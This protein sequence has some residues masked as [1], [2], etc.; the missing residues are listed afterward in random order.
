MTIQKINWIK[1]LPKNRMIKA[2][3][4]E[5]DESFDCV[6]NRNK[7]C[8]SR[9]PLEVADVRN[10]FLAKIPKFMELFDVQNKA[11][12]K[13]YLCVKLRYVILNEVRKLRNNK[14]KI[15]N[16]RPILS[17]EAIENLY[18]DNDS[19]RGN[20]DFS[21]LNKFEYLVFLEIFESCSSIATAARELNVTRYL[22]YK[23][24]ETIKIK[25]KK[26]LQ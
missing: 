5:Y 10:I 17:D 6:I 11:N 20:I 13:S 9:T 24:L 19:Y 16:E 1:K 12:L 3:L 22:I 4:R 2:V 7:W 23:T 8:F 15:L 26:Q 14:H 25:I 21:V 18:I